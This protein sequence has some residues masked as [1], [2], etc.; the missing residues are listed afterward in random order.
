MAKKTS[1]QG[2]KA[3][4]KKSGQPSVED[5]RQSAADVK[6]DV[7]PAAKPAKVDKPA[8]DSKD[9]RKAAKTDKPVKSA[10]KSAKAG[11]Q[12]PK[13]PNVFTRIITYFKNVRTEVKRTTWPS[14]EEV[15]RMSIIVVGVLLFFGVL[16]FLLDW[17]MNWLMP[18]YADLAQNF[19]AP[20]VDAID[21]GAVPDSSIPTDTGTPTNP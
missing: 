15:L 6:K 14:R 1:K 2:K 19:S 4:T 8:G 9:Q 11:K 13:K 7:A 17:V 10:Q 20:P 18:L 21:P 3:N 16:I 12:A 5:S